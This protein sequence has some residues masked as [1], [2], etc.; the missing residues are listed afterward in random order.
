MQKTLKKSLRETKNIRFPREQS[1]VIMTVLLQIKCIMYV[2]SSFWQSSWSVLHFANSLSKRCMVGKDIPITSK[3]YKLTH[4]IICFTFI[5][6]IAFHYLAQ[7][8]T[9]LSTLSFLPTL[10]I[11][12]MLYRI[13]T[14]LILFEFVIKFIF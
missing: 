9:H 6:Y 10:V 8:F 2:F 1:R 5:C 7:M 4:K 12:T 14:F 11:Y 3:V 13:K